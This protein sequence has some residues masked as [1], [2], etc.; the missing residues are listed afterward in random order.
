MKYRDQMTPMG[1][2]MYSITLSASRF[3][4][5]HMALY[6]IL[7]YTWGILTTL[8]GWLV[9]G[10]VRVFLRKKVVDHGRFGPSH[11]AM[12]YDSWGGLELG[13]NFLIAD[14]MPQSWTLHTKQHELGHT[15]QNAV[16]GP[17]AI[18]I[19]FLPSVVRY[20]LDRA[21]RIEKDYDAA[22]FEGSA[23]AIGEEYYGMHSG[24][25]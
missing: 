17:L 9:L 11:Y 21:G 15:F 10:F 13:T 6:Y 18:F 23:T 16:W 7:S 25:M 14:K 3:L 1:R 12:L 4:M 5:R 20:W 24:K 2:A 8:A 22:W 19:S